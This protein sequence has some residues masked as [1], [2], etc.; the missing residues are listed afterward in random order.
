[1]GSDIRRPHT[2][3]SQRI[4][5][6]FPWPQFRR[7]AHVDFDETVNAIVVVD[8]VQKW[9]ATAGRF[10]PVFNSHSSTVVDRLQPLSCFQPFDE[11]GG[12]V[13]YF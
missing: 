3:T 2:K 7:V 4:C 8:Q 6:W 10:E 12:D 1:M 5:G 13:S 11:G 9:Q